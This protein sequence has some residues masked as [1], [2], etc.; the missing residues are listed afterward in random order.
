MGDGTLLS[1]IL[2]HIPMLRWLLDLVGWRDTH[3]MHE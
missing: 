2:P 1:R 3:A